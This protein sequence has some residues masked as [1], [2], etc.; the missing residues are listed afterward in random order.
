MTTLLLYAV[1][2]GS[3]LGTS[4]LEDNLNLFAR[5]KREYNAQSTCKKLKLPWLG[6]R[7]FQSFLCEFD[8]TGDLT[9]LLTGNSYSSFFY[10]SLVDAGKHKF[11]K[12]IL[13]AAPTCLIHKKTLYAEYCRD[14]ADNLPRTLADVKPDIVIINQRYWSLQQ[15]R[16]P[17]TDLQNDPLVDALREDWAM[18]SNYTKKI[19]I[20]E[21]ASGLP[22]TTDLLKPIRSNA[23]HLSAYAMPL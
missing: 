4:Y 20:I 11:K 14:V 21:P 13:A 8:G 7:S 18:I 2:V 17:P 6:N 19:I 10:Q 9:V 23:P 1:L 5:C 15:F 12:L 22:R 16:N 3:A